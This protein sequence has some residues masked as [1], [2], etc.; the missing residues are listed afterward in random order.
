V[1]N[2]QTVYAV[3]SVRIKSATIGMSSEEES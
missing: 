1:L 2:C 3:T